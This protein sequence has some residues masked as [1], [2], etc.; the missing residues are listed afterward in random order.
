LLTHAP[1]WRETWSDA[2]AERRTERRTMALVLQAHGLGGTVAD[3]GALRV[4]SDS[5]V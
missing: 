5:P 1:R 4:L 3:E 2:A